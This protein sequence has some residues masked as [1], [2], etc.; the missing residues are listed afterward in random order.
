MARPQG[1]ESIFFLRV[2]SVC[3]H[4]PLTC[5]A[6]IGVVE[7]ARLMRERAASSLVVTHLG[8]PIGVLSSDDLRDLVAEGVNGFG[9]TPVADLMGRQP[10]TVGLHDYV[11]EAISRM[12]RH[13]VQRL[14][15]LDEQGKLF[16]LLC[17]SD[18][19]QLQARTPLYTTREIEAARSIEELRAINLRMLEIVSFAHRAGADIKALAQ[20]ISHLNDTFTVRVI[21][22][23]ESREGLPFPEGAAYLA[24]GS[25][26]RSEQTLRTD[27]DSALLYR[28]DL[29]AE[30][31]EKLAR[32]AER[33][34][35]ALEEVGVPRCPGATM[36]SNPVWRKSLSGWKGCLDQWLSVPKPESMVDF[37]MFQDF[38]TL[39]GD[40]ELELQL[41]AHLHASV[42]RHALFLP[43][44][45]RHI[46]HFPPPLRLFGRFRVERS[47]KHRGALDLKKA[48]IFAI[49]EGASLL[50]LEAG[51]SGGSTWDKLDRLRDKGILAETSYNTLYSAFSSLSRL[52]LQQQLLDLGEGRT[53]S[54]H[55]DPMLL[56]RRD[57]D[58]LREALRG[59]NHLLRLIRERYRLDLISR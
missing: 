7:A 46:A 55:V 44:M 10:V 5:P 27:Q 30:Q 14:A 21:A 22:L 20:L 19:V 31:Q 56:S 12:A 26:G 50:G 43:Y 9:D 35:A 40:A 52:R 32:F 11:F 4:P 8:Q 39:H 15:V 34:V 38:R 18:L 33:L 59:V 45:A 3:R 29:P 47:G 37:G 13:N 42:R 16:G 28:D 17:D 23:L 51:F 48:G 57:Q 2:G 1:E 53:P 41:R 54:N 58:Q 49:T 24:L 36:I 25:E 6:E